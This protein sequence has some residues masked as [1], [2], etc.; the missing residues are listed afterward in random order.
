MTL[1]VVT[2]YRDS[3]AFTVM[4]DIFAHFRQ[5]F[6]LLGLGEEIRNELHLN[7]FLA[8]FKSRVSATSEPVWDC[9]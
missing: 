7:K 8:P 9:R 1:A 2:I 3:I 5:L 6:L 4:F